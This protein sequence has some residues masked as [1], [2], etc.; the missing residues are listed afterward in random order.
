M[1][2]IARHLPFENWPKADQSA[3]ERAVQ[4]GSLLEGSGP[5][6][7]WAD[8]TKEVT[9]RQYGYWLSFVLETNTSHLSPA[10]RITPEIVLAYSEYLTNSISINAACVYLNNL[11]RAI[12][13]LCP[14]K[15]WK[16]LYQFNQQLKQ[17]S[18]GPTRNKKV[19]IQDSQMLVELGF[20]LMGEV[21]GDID[22]YDNLPGK[23]KIKVRTQYR[24][25]LMIALLALRPIRRGN[26]VSICIGKELVQQGNQWLLIFDGDAVK[27]GLPLEFLVP[28]VLRDSLETYLEKVRPR[29]PY[30]NQFTHL[31]MGNEKVPLTA[32][33]C[34]K[35]I[36]RRTKKHLGKQISPHLFRDCAASTIATCSPAQV[37]AIP[38]VLGHTHLDTA[39]KYYIQADQI[40]AMNDYRNIL[41]KIR[42]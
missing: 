41:E 9:Q 34:N 10:L 4:P 30:A 25:G 1:T 39:Q 32:S 18:P 38:S 22:H 3:W 40:Q 36:S 15:D 35:C 13:V 12:R 23:Q 21:E 11:W 7:H 16:W 28:D 8:S 31:W 2:G 33:G 19:L 20:S 37:Q 27:N 42:K 17:Q 14:E 5:A 26:F 24:D 29:F 6:A